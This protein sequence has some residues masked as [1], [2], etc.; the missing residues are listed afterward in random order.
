M[1]RVLIVDDVADNVALL[2]AEMEDEGYEVFEA[3][4]GAAPS[5]WHVRRPPTRSSS[6][7]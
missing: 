5:S 6:T 3:Y 2:A 4:D 1:A 7:S